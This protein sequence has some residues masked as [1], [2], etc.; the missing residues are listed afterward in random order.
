[1]VAQKDFNKRGQ[2]DI[3]IGTI[4]LIILG[5]VVI[6]VLVLG[7]TGTFGDIFGKRA[8]IPGNVAAVEQG[9]KVAVQAGLIAD[10]CYSFKKISDTEYINC[11]D[12]RISAPGFT[13][14]C[15]DTTVDSAATQ[16]CESLKGQTGGLKKDV[17]IRYA[18]GESAPLTAATKVC[19]KA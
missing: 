11:E 13:S 17:T 1:M 7:F 9:C 18:T 12:N 8:A 4:L 2:R 10:Y 6:I 19:K 14:D 15:V 3:S 5:V 16:L